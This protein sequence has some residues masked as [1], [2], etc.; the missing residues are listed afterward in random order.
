[1]S[2]GES[3][4]F[5]SAIVYYNKKTN[6]AH[7][8]QIFTG[9]C[10]LA[11]SGA[12]HLTLI[13]DDWNPSFGT[14]NLIKV[15]LNGELDLLFDSNDGFYWIHDD[16][17]HNIA[18]FANEILPKFHYVFKRSCNREIIAKFGSA[19]AK[20][21]PLGLNYDL[22]SRRNA[23]DR[24]HY[25]WRDRL[26]KH[27]KRSP[28]LCKA[29]GMAPNS[30]FYFE[31]FEHPPLPNPIGSTPQILLL[32]RLWDPVA[33]DIGTADFGVRESVGRERDLINRTRIKCIE[34]CRRAFS[35]HFVGGLA[36]TAYAERVAPHLIA[37]K[38]ITQKQSCI[39]LIRRSP[40]CVATTGLH[41]ST[42]WRFGEYVAASRAIVSE[43]VYD[44]LPGEFGAPSNYLE[45]STVEQLLD[46]IHVLVADRALMKAMMWNNYSYYRS[47][48]RPDA[49]VLNALL[50]ALP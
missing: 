28:L 46:A 33:V 23:I 1:M 25:G 7:S 27:A 42:G 41:L 35:G 5:V 2:L 38:T 34:A 39:A 15:T 31:S 19:A 47:Y 16:L 17:E 48:G 21:L 40:S 32:T 43:R 4:Q 24:V 9:F 13:E 45:F 8:R 49:V 50:Q 10:E 3:M 30:F 22:T 14:E 37:P 44:T 29:I 36:A 11:H 12:I 18:Y 26:E 20:F 6:G